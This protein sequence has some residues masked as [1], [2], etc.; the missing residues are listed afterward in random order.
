[1]SLMD[2]MGLRGTVRVVLRT[3][4]GRNADSTRYEVSVSEGVEFVNFGTILLAQ[5]NILPSANWYLESCIAYIIGDISTICDHL[6]PTPLDMERDLG[7]NT[8]RFVRINL[9]M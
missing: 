8:I 4:E 6:D 2:W 3:E 5:L 1:M 7:I 9:C